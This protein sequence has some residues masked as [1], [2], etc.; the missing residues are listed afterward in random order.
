MEDCRPPTGTVT[1]TPPD[2]PCRTLQNGTNRWGPAWSIGNPRRDVPPPE[3]NNWLV[4]TKLPENGAASPNRILFANTR[5]W[6]G[7]VVCE[8][9][10]ELVK[11]ALDPSAVGVIP[12]LMVAKTPRCASRG[13]SRVS[14]ISVAETVRARTCRS[15]SSTRSGT[16]RC[17]RLVLLKS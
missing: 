8:L 15:C 5:E 17:D 1:L 4:G 16:R 6:S 13:L 10:K 9:P 7:L 14:W 11:F 3:K 12:K 2:A